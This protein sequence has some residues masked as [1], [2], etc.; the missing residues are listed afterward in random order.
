MTTVSLKYN[1]YLIRT[2][3]LVDGKKPK[4]NSAL[5]V[6]KRRLQEWIDK[7]PQNLHEEFLEDE[8]IIEYTGTADDFRDV[9]EAFS[10]HK[11]KTTITILLMI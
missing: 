3:I 6:G 5:I 9:E 8:F 7:L 10:R 4:E 1:P 11:Y 2:E